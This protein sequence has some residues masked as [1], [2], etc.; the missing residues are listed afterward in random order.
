MNFEDLKTALGDW[1][2]KDPNQLTDT[3]RGQLINMAQREILRD[4]DLRFGEYSY[5]LNT[6]ASQDDYPVPTGYS[7]TYS[8]WYM[9]SGSKVNV[10]YMTKE[11]F[12]AKFGAN[13]TTGKP[14]NYTLWNNT[15][16]LG[17]NPD[18]IIN[19][20]WNIRRTLPDLVNGSPNNSN[21]LVVFA[22]DY[23]LFRGLTLATKFMFEDSRAPLWEAEANRIT[24]SIVREH[25]REASTHRRPVTNE[26]G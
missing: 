26:P 4:Y 15:V 5:A 23:L 12:D 18:G 25:S 21:D 2:G 24:A 1:S 9:N 20:N 17:P 7:R 16:F 22:W 8:M 10:L 11:E 13:S 6:V 3:V 14:A 19:I